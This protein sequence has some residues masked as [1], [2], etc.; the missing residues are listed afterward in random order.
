MRD[1]ISI[2]AVMWK[3]Q[4]N[5]NGEF[6][7]RIRI[8]KNR[9]SKYKTIPNIFVT[10]E[11]WE[12][13]ESVLDQLLDH[14]ED[15]NDIM[16]DVQE[17]RN[18][19]D[20]FE[21]ADAWVERYNN[22]KN[23]GFYGTAKSKINKFRKFIGEDKVIFFH[24]ITHSL[25]LN[26]QAHLKQ[27]KT[28]KGRNANNAN[29]RAQALKTLRHIFRVATRE[30]VIPATLWP[31][32]GIKHEKAQTMKKAFTSEQLNIFRNHPLE[33]GSLHWHSRNM[34][35]LCFNGMGMRV[36]DCL[37][38]KEEHIQNDRIVYS[39]GKSGDIINIGQTDEAKRI[40]N[41]YKGSK[42]E[43]LIPVLSTD[44]SVSLYQ[45]IKKAEARINKA[46][47]QIV[48]AAEINIKLSTH[49]A[50]HTWAELARGS[51]VSMDFIQEAF[52][53]EDQRT[54]RVYTK[55]F[56]NPVMDEMNKK[57]TSL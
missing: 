34:F 7:V 35:L 56:S 13:M 51:G 9:K 42:S 17:E 28:P 22:E 39:M 57:V 52:G 5:K 15:I 49:V 18:S 1:K 32:E 30:K 23:E 14:L 36:S 20:F 29:T 41:Y 45:R 37:K 48:N 10:E 21:F 24:E 55:G 53:H 19:V 27:L 54:T 38:L 11:R 44:K 40:L 50:R 4:A 12:T 25:L 6:P 33:K 2:K 26:Y 31:F 3:H 46:L 8:T 43:Y 16:R 47:K